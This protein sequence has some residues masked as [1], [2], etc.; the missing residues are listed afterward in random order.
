MAPSVCVTDAGS[1][2][3]SSPSHRRHV[4]STSALPRLGPPYRGGTTRHGWSVGPFH[5][6]GVGHHV[7]ADRHAA[8]SQDIARCTPPDGAGGG[9]RM[10]DNVSW[11]TRRHDGI[12]DTPDGYA[13][14]PVHWARTS[15]GSSRCRGASRAGHLPRA[16]PTDRLGQ[17]VPASWCEIAS[18]LFERRSDHCGFV[19]LH[20]TDTMAYASSALSIL[21]PSFDGP[22]VVT[23]SQIPIARARSD[24]RQNFIGSLEVAATAGS[25]RSPSSSGRPCSGRTGP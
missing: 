4:G 9:R 12:V 2:S 17:R 15:T 11:S 10:G 7:N 20:G 18:I 14:V 16:R 24:G 1:R 19:V 5:V 3:R 25:P 13:P 22:V 6:E 23:G 8:P 21:L